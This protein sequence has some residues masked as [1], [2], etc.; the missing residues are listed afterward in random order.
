MD[1]RISDHDAVAHLMQLYIDGSAGDTAKLV[2]AFH[3]EARMFGQFGTVARA[4]PIQSF[5]DRVAKASPPLAGPNY[6]ARVA[7]ID[8]VGEAGVATLVEQDYSGKNF[9]DWF[10]VAKLEGRWWIVNKT[11][12]VTGDAPTA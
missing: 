4:V 5:I 7:S 8:L 9:V 12:V 3:P 6:Q 2:E 1:K 10:S 11:Y